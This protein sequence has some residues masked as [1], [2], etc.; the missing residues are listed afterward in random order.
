MTQTNNINKSESVLVL[1][2]YTLDDIK[3]CKQ[4]DMIS[5][6]VSE[7]LVLNK[8][9]KD[10]YNIDE[11]S[12][13]IVIAFKIAFNIEMT[14]E[15]ISRNYNLRK[16]IVSA[17]S[18]IITADKTALLTKNSDLIAENERLKQEYEK[19]KSDFE[20]KTKTKKAK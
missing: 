10:N 5:K 16:S 13:A 9:L 18:E 8:L 15:Q 14:S 12:D 6:Y 20:N 4:K 11:M 7:N 17:N 1:R 3:D 19:L 2:Q